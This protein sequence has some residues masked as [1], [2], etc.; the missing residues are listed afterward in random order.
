MTP[1]RFRRAAFAALALALAF[2]I[3]S[4][5]PQ[6]QA[7]AQELLSYFTMVSGETLPAMPTAIPAP[8][9]TLEVELMPLQ[10]DLAELEDCGQVISPLSSTFICQLQDAQAKLGFEVRSFPARYVQEQF[11][12]MEV[13]PE[14]RI[15][16]I[17]FS[18]YS[19]SQGIGDFPEDCP[20]CAVYEEAVQPVQV[21][22]YQAEYAAGSFI[23]EEDKSMI[24]NP[25]AQHYALRWKE[26]EHWYALSLEESASNGLKPVEIKAKI[27]QLAE[28][29]VTIDQGAE[30]LSAANQ[31]SIKDSA[32][33]TIKEPGILPE[34]FQQ[35]PDGSWSN[36]TNMPRVGMKY[37]Y[38]ADGT[39]VNALTLY[40]MLI[41]SDHQ[42]LRREFALI[43][44]HQSLVDGEWTD[45]GRDEEIRI[46]EQIGYYMEADDP[47]CI[48]LYWRDDEREYM[49]AYYWDPAF[50]GRLDKETLIA[51]AESLK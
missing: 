48:G 23:F 8:T 42:T 10:P 35:V 31:P 44:Q 9:Y 6:G 21:G 20:G 5:T 24:W 2:I 26:G 18:G 50:G 12:F 43:Y 38:K 4:L 30:L 39:F 33:F 22:A 45:A 36:L 49:L 34:G 19:L 15:A 41:P 40:Q 27:I 16:V 13:Y 11:R 29:L 14:Y 7:F 37:V 28:N 46:H 51:I 47:G 25:N 17:H 3:L 1:N 32:G